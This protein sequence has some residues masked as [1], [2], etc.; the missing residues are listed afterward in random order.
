MGN[1]NSSFYVD[2]DNSTT[3]VVTSNDNPNPSTGNTAAPSSFYQGGEGNQYATLQNVDTLTAEFDADL[4][5]A[6]AAQAAAASSASNA[7]TSASSAASSLATFLASGATATPLVDS[8]TGSVGTSPKWAHEDHA[9]PADYATAAAVL[10]GGQG[11]IAPAM[12]GAAAVGTSAH[13]AHEDHVHPTDTTRAPLASPALTGTPTAPTAVAQTNNTQLA[14]TAYVDAKEGSAT[15]L[16]DGTAAVGTSHLFA[17]QDHVHPTDTTRAP[18]ASPTFTGTPAAPTP[19]VN[20]STTKLATTAYVQG[21]AA[22]A[23][24]LMDGTAAVGTGTRWAK[25]DHRHPTD[26]SLAPLASPALTGTPTAPTATVGTNNT[27]LATTAFV[28]ANSAASGVTSIAGNTGA[29]TLGDG[30][31]NATNVLKVD[32]S[33]LRGYLNG[34]TLSTAGSSATYGIDVG[35]AV[36]STANAA[37]LMKLTSAYTKTT[38]AWALGTAAGSLDTGTIAAS[39]WYH[40]HLIKRPDTGVVDVLLS[41]SATAPTLPT[42]Y[43]LFRR[44]GSMKTNSSSQWVLFKQVGDEFIWD[45]FVL[46]VNGSGLSTTSTLFTMSVPPGVSVLGRFRF[47]F[48]TTSGTMAMDI[49]SPLITTRAGAAGSYLSFAV[50]SSGVG[51]GETNVMT[52][53]SSQI[54]AVANASGGTQ[55]TYIGTHSWIDT[56]GKLS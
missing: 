52:N 42:N 24:P 36:D 55:L 7:S 8:G 44:I 22:T 2:G 51:V 39:T 10:A 56:R 49:Q 40:V 25:E 15:P 1:T 11:T 47:E 43:T 46:D 3:G 12:D 29:F 27:Q 21:Q 23:T 5:A 19:A 33:F 14:T 37:G 17:R 32:P 30:L 45:V 38:S 48:T 26:T 13:W 18:L 16:V 6:Q 50:G 53:T 35:V 20:D 4:A 28:L 31:A 41:L 9:H 54:R 34:L